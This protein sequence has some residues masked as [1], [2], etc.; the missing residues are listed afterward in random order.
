M[1]S[2]NLVTFLQKVNTDKTH[3]L[4]SVVHEFRTPLQSLKLM[5]Q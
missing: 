2:L 1:T 3:F 5:L 4:S